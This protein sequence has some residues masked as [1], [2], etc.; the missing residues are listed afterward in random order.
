[1]EPINQMFS[2]VIEKAKLRFR[3]G[4]KETDVRQEA[5]IQNNVPVVK[6]DIPSVNVTN[7]VNPDHI[8]LDIEGGRKEENKN[9]VY[10]NPS[11]NVI[12][13]KYL[14]HNEENLDH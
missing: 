5:V 11:K 3:I 10:N 8:E 7:N 2:G 12:V 4:K 9:Y 13:E 1:M 14:D 6:N